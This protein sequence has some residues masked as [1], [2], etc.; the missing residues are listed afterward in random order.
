MSSVTFD[1][2]LSDAVWH[3]VEW[4]KG[5]TYINITQGER[6]LS[7]TTDFNPYHSLVSPRINI[8]VG[9]KPYLAGKRGFL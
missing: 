6:S 2:D 1:E 5:Q 8:Y 9:G 3:T 7:L 4:V